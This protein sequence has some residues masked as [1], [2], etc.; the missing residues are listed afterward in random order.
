VLPAIFRC[1][2]D[3]LASIVAVVVMLS[4]FKAFGSPDLVE[5]T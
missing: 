1:C 3:G 5:F 4:P 2:C